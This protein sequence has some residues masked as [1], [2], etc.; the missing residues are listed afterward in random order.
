[1]KTKN[2]GISTII[3]FLF[4]LQPFCQGQTCTPTATISPEPACNAHVKGPCDPPPT[5]EAVASPVPVAIPTEFQPPGKDG[6][7]KWRIFQPNDGKGR[8]PVVL[9]IHGGGFKAGSYFGEHIDTCAQDMADA[10]YYAL[11][12]NY[13]LAP[14][15]YI[16]G[17]ED[18]SDPLSGRPVEQTNDIKALVR[19]AR[20]DTHCYNG[21]VVA[22]GGSGGGSHALWV[23]LD[24]TASDGWPN[25]HASDRLEA[26]VGLSGAYDYSDRT[27]ES[28][29]DLTT[30]RNDVE[31]YTNTCKREDPTGPID[32]KRFSPVTKVTSDAPPIYIINT[33]EDTQPWHQ[34]VDMQCALENAGLTN[35]KAW[36]IPNPSQHSFAYWHS[37]ICE[38]L[39]CTVYPLVKDS[40]IQ[41]L[42]S[43]VTK[44]P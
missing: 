41:F 37:P 40:V 6:L 8:W 19:A 27:P 12:V 18:H 33:E 39:P 34:I 22:V 42:D 32:E 17:Q 7:L 4:V 35:F 24:K 31:N 23:T 28:Y 26:A 1:M 9:V 44:L 16:P 13:R 2:P 30:F 21:Q 15:G 29:M 14:C 11:V 3:L 10:G 25:W 43:H 20:A 36:T 38:H 5:S